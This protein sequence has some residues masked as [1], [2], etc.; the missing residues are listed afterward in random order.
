MFV[1]NL[2]TAPSRPSSPSAV[3]WIRTGLT[4]AAVL[5]AG[6]TARSAE[7]LE[8]EGLK[9]GTGHH[10]VVTAS[11][12]QGLE[13][14]IPKESW[15]AKGIALDIQ[16]KWDESYEAY[17]KAEQEFRAQLTKRPQ[18]AKLIRGWLAKA[19][20]Q[21]S[22]S[23]RLK[24]RL[25]QSWGPPSASMVFYRAAA[26]HNKWL[27]I[28]AFTG[29]GPVALQQEILKEYQQALSQSQHY[30]SARIAL[31]AMYHEIGQHAKGRQEFARVQSNMRVWLA[32]E[33]A[34]YYTTAGQHDKAFELLEKAIKYNSSN[35]RHILRSNDFDRLRDDPRFVK[36]VGEP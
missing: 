12:S 14:G 33:V 6:R 21:R 31:A 34:Y 19:R 16:Q 1:P 3:F 15:Y 20:F 11:P 5:L 7:R 24:Y 8:E 23:Q 35:K 25:R 36:L 26:L 18:W 4:I 30:D 22:Q 10:V 29:R 9:T 27:A 17:R 32:M 13:V 28:R 2:S